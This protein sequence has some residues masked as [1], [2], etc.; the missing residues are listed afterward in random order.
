MSKYLP[1]HNSYQKK[2]SLVRIVD[3]LQ[4]QV[5]FEGGALF[6]A[7]NLLDYAD[8]D[9]TTGDFLEYFRRDFMPSIDA[10]ILADKRLLAKHINQIYLAK[11]SLQILR[12]LI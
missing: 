8:V 5:L 11:G 3:T 6:P 2:Q 7:N 10:N 9:R 1:N 4:K 12:F